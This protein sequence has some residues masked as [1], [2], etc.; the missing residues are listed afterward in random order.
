MSVVALS[1]HFSVSKMT[2]EIER[3]AEETEEGRI[4]SSN[5]IHILKTILI[6]SESDPILNMIKIR[7][8]KEISQD[9]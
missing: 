2:L 3:I 8:L 4:P 7:F 9:K 1:R 5:D 6:I